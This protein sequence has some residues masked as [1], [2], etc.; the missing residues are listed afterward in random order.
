MKQVT[1]LMAVLMAA[2]MALAQATGQPAQQGQ[3][4]GIT[5]P[6]AQQQQPQQQQQQQPPS[7]QQQQPPATQQPAQ[8]RQPQAKSQE[9][10]Q[11]FMAVLNNPDLTAADVGA[12]EFEAKFPQSE[13]KSMLYEQLMLKSQ[14]SNNADKAVDF[15]RRAIEANPNS[16][17]ALITTATYLAERTRETDID[18]DEKLADAMKFSER[19]LANVDTMALPPNLPAEQVTAV[20]NQLRAMGHNSMGAAE[21]TRANNA[22][23]EKH[24]KEAIKFLGDRPDSITFF[25]LALA[26]D[27]QNKYAEALQA[28]E[29]S[30]QLANPQDPATPA[31][32][33]ERDRLKK[34]AGGAPGA[35]NTAAPPAQKPQ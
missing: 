16:A 30:V 33:A 26:L 19:G 24:F 32:V 20:K 23:A 12:R 10:Y 6:G 35:A 34:L 13:L 15:G 29:R 31:M 2:S 4:E 1:I 21:F 27:K 8:P 5:L 18:K 7:A 22:A 11:A 28:A 3:R 25:R 17:L 14:E 9:E